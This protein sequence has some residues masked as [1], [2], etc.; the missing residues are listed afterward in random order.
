MRGIIF[1][2]VVNIDKLTYAASLDSL[3][4]AKGNPHYAFE[5]Q[6]ICEGPALGELLEKHQPGAVM[7]LA[8]ESHVDRL[9][10]GPGERPHSVMPV[11]QLDPGNKD[12]REPGLALEALRL[13][14]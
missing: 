4:G 11:S 1:A 8:A 7:N 3:A 5:K 10:D 2:R 14:A 13:K 12:D 9:I 6:C